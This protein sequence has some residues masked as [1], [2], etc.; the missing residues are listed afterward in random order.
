MDLGFGI[1]VRGWRFGLGVHGSGFGIHGSSLGFGV[2]VRGSRFWLGVRGVCT[3]WGSGSGVCG[4]GLRLGL[5]VCDSGLGFEVW[6]LVFAVLVR[7]S[8]FRLD[9]RGLGLG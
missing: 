4:L 3:V 9:V 6:G 7:G 1:Q 8:R 5:G 2:C